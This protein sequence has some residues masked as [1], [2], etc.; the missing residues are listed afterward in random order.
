MSSRSPSDH[1]QRQ[2]NSV[3]EAYEWMPRALV[4]RRPL[5]T[6]RLVVICRSVKDSIKVKGVMFE[7]FR[8]VDAEQRLV[9]YDFCG[10]E[11]AYDIIRFGIA[12]FGCERP[13]S[14]KDKKLS[15]SIG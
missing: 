8:S 10:G 2:L 13:F 7:S 6:R 12:F 3:W 1:T 9:T 4:G 11:T 5:S 15:A 14:E